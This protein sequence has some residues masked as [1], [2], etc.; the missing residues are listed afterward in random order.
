MGYEWVG[1]SEYGYVDECMGCAHGNVNVNVSEGAKGE[2]DFQWWN[3]T[4][5]I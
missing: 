1:R 2:G 4:H 3:E 5:K